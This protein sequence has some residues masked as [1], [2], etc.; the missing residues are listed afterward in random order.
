M[1]GRDVPGNMIEIW[2]RHFAG[3]KSVVEL[4]GK[5]TRLHDTVWS[6]YGAALSS[7]RWL[8]PSAL[9]PR[10]VGCHYRCG[11]GGAGM[12]AHPYTRGLFGE[13]TGGIGRSRGACSNR[14]GG[15][16]SAGQ[17]FPGKA[18]SWPFTKVREIWH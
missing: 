10:C 18:G 5:G 17:R 8:P 2:R 4:Q 6:S 15:W 13:A 14:R 16:I 7:C 1:S 11:G 9:K 12:R 3:C